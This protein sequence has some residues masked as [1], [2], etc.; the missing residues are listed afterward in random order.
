LTEAVSRT[1]AGLLAVVLA[2]AGGLLTSR[3]LRSEAAEIPAVAWATSGP[4]SPEPSPS[5]A[6]RSSAPPAPARS[7][8]TRLDVPAIG[9][10]T[11]LLRLGLNPDRTVEVPPLDADAPAGWYENSVTPGETGAAVILGHV[12]TAREGPAV[13]YRLGALKPGDHITV[14]R[15]DGSTINFTVTRVA[16]Y[17]KLEF[18]TREVY[19]PVAYPEL[20]LLTCGGSFDRRQRSYLDNIVVF[21]RSVAGDR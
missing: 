18:P 16:R 17:P 5:R 9:V 6:P 1:V 11:T 10:H 20:R 8:P 3:G 2:V 15:A 4:P 7:V 21:A 12:D 13:F 19:G 14:R